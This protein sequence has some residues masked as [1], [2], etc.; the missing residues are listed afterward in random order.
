M[1]STLKQEIMDK[2]KE[3]QQKESIGYFLARLPG[4]VV[5]QLLSPDM[6]AERAWPT[7]DR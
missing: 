2:L 3:K 7:E 1:V 6:Q 4:R 5:Y